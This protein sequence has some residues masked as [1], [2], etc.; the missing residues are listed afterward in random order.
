M[1]LKNGSMRM[2]SGTHEECNRRI[3][4]EAL[5]PERNRLLQNLT[6]SITQRRAARRQGNHDHVTEA[7]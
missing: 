2:Q 6:R 4:E 7:V 3:R 5:I 1:R